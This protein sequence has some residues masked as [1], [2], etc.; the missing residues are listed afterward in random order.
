MSAPAPEPAAPVVDSGA[1][2]LANEGGDPAPAVEEPNLE[3]FD[4][5]NPPQD[6]D[7]AAETKPQGEEGKDP[8]AKDGQPSPEDTV[9][10][11]LAKDMELS[12]EEEDRLRGAFLATPNGRRMLEARKVLDSLE[13][14]PEI[15]PATGLNKGGLGRRPTR[16]EILEGDQASLAM[17]QMQHDFDTNPANW[18]SN[19]FGYRDARGE[20]VQRPGALQVLQQIPDHLLKID[21]EG[22][23][24]KEFAGRVVTPYLDQIRNGIQDMVARAPRTH[25]G[26]L[27]KEAREEI[28][29]HAQG[30]NNLEKLFLGEPQRIPGFVY[31]GQIYDP[32]NPDPVT[33]AKAEL[34][35]EKKRIADEK[36]KEA[37]QRAQ[38]IISHIE[39]NIT[40]TVRQDAV[41]LLKAAGLAQ[42]VAQDVFDFRVE[43]FMKKVIEAT[44]GNTRMGIDPL[45]PRGFQ[46]YLIQADRAAR[47]QLDPAIPI[48]DYSRLAHAAMRK[49][50]TPFKNST[51]T[52]SQ[53]SNDALHQRAATAA[54]RTEAGAGGAPLATTPGQQSVPAQRPPDMDPSEWTRQRVLAAMTP[55]AMAGAIRH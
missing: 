32:E 43:N 53:A 20:L 15:D 49:L 36:A 54:K 11:L 47:G 48:R 27:T 50:I 37:Q 9:K 19:F 2:P 24:H 46:T 4:F 16:E 45:N 1:A 28:L 38:G 10:E 12:K 25:T 23:L 8:A 3:E 6:T 29:A 7:P 55:Q 26:E 5:E 39:A 18:I 21:P 31:G 30:L 41:N 44:S 40:S 13:A 51:I 33:K 35:A 34:A 52:S 22:N 17:L 14:P 42:G